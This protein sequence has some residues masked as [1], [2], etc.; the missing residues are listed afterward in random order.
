[1][2]TSL[3]QLCYLQAMQ[4][5]N[6]LSSCN[7]YLTLPWQ[8]ISTRVA[9][10][11][12]LWCPNLIFHKYYLILYFIFYALSHN[13]ILHMPW[14]EHEQSRAWCILIFVYAWLPKETFFRPACIIFLKE[15]CSYDTFTCPWNLDNE[16]CSPTVLLWH[17]QNVIDQFSTL[18]YNQSFPSL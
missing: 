9:M 8:E 13:G 1:M 10:H 16:I 15:L 5:C 3:V 11:Q 14:H 4:N 18:I 6:K 12:Q 7:K 2:I 17:V